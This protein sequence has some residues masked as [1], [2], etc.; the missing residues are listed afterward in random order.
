MEPRGGVLVDDKDQ[1][2]APGARPR[3]GLWG[4]AE[5]AF[6]AVFLSPMVKNNGFRG[7]PRLIGLA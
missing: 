1:P 5:F 2:A 3:L 7:R 6:G 4:L